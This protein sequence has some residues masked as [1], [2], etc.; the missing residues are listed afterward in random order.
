[1]YQWKAMKISENPYKSM[2]IIGNQTNPL[3]SMKIN[4]N[5]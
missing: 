5:Q 2:K 4:N 3:K 1:M